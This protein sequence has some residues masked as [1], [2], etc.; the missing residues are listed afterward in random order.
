MYD[1]HYRT[2]ST[3]L[4]DIPSDVPVIKEQPEIEIK[5]PKPLHDRHVCVLILIKSIAI[6]ISVGML[7]TTQFSCLL[8][9]FALRMAVI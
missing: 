7:C 5:P 9:R 6:K 2:S 1:P 8:T 4:Q 3:V